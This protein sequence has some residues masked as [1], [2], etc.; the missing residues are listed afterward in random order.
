MTHW[1]ARALLALCAG[2]F[3]LGITLPFVAF[4]RLFLFTEAVSLSGLV[5]RLWS[6]G[7]LALAAVVGLF[8]ILL[9][10]LKIVVLAAEATGLSQGIGAAANAR[11]HWL[12]THMSR[13]SMMDVMLVALA[14]FAVKT[15]GLGDAVTQPGLWCYAASAMI[16]GLLPVLA[17]KY[18]VEK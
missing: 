7:D 3:V 4:E 10:T 18:W 16:S 2:L 14:V 5:A 6:D 9:P 17:E 1:I 15:S 8:S 11:L 13:W 12:L